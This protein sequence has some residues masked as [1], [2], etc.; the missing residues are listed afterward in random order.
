MEN[1]KRK[2]RSLMKEKNILDKR[3]GGEKVFFT[4][5]AIVLWVHTLTL[6]I[7]IIFMVMTSL[8]S[9]GEYYATK[10]YDFPTQW[11]FEN[12]KLAFSSLKYRD[13]TF[14]DMLY[15]STWFTL[16]KSLI[17]E[18]A[19]L[20]VGYAL[21]RYKFPGKKIITTFIL[22][23][24][25]LPLFGS[26]GAYMQLL[27]DL[28]LHDNRLLLI[29]TS[30]D[31]LGLMA[32]LY[33]AAYAG[34]S[35]SYKEAAEID[36][37]SRLQIFAFIETPMIGSFV[38]VRFVLA[39]M[40]NWPVYEPFLLYLPSYANLA[41]GLYKLQ[42]QFSGGGENIPIYFCGLLIS[43]IPTTILFATV[44]KKMFTSLAIG[45]LKG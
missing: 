45:G 37:A 12:Y 29:A 10:L 39:L 33:S 6:I 35:N 21:A 23:R 8:K 42:T 16:E 43:A 17:N 32:L 25:V 5:I 27:H 34:L 4:I 9:S 19:P 20:M 28:N 3:S 13:I 18:L 1:I 36:G 24:T 11:L 38:L 41:M 30:W 40:G 2:K 31:G 7:P 15:N 14:F 44:S 26:G 22:V